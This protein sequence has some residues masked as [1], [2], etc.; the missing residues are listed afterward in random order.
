MLGGR[1]DS[2]VNVPTQGLELFDQ[3]LLGLC[4]SPLLTAKIREQGQGLE[5]VVVLR[6]TMAPKGVSRFLL[7]RRETGRRRPT[8]RP[9]SS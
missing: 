1:Q 5:A 4:E 3:E 7:G 8:I 6:G 9:G 2:T